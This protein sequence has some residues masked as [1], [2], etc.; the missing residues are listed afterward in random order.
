MTRAPVDESFAYM[1]GVY[2]LIRGFNHALDWRPFLER[3][4]SESTS[5]PVKDLWIGG[6]GYK[7]DSD[8]L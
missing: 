1:K 5:T 2:T 8:P 3:V 7:F 4:G 6:E